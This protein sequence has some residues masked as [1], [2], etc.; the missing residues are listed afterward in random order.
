MAVV[1]LFVQN[2][3]TRV[4][5]AGQ[6]HLTADPW[7]TDRSTPNPI[8]DLL[9]LL[10]PQRVVF[11]DRFER[12]GNSSKEPS[13]SRRFDKR[14]INCLRNFVPLSASGIPLEIPGSRG[15]LTVGSE[16]GP[17]LSRIVD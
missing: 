9:E 17:R 13:S 4:G 12:A 7:G 11:H 15:R 1:P 3:R 8:A 5:F 16:A 2:G 14:T 10:S 6:V